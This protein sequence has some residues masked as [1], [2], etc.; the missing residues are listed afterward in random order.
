MKA[1]KMVRTTPRAIPECLKATGIERMPVPSEAFSK[2]V[3][4]SLSLWTRVTER[5]RRE[6][7]CNS[8]SSSSNG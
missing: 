4:V 5:E 7:K 6:Q 1:V 8:S 3:K 2:C